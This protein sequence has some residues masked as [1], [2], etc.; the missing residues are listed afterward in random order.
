MIIYKPFRLRRLVLSS[1]GIHTI[2]A[3][4]LHLS[5][6]QSIQ[7]LVLSMNALNDWQD[8][9][10][11]VQWCPELKSLSLAGNPLSERLFMADPSLSSA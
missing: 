1:N 11:L 2:P 8:V 9:D 3:L 6:L 10:R 4:E 7:N 5:P